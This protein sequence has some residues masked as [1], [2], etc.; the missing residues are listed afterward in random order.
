MSLPY[1]NCLLA[2]VA[3][4]APPA[5]NQLPA[6]EN[7]KP[8]PPIDVAAEFLTRAVAGQDADALKFTVPGT[9]SEAKVGEIRRAGYTST[10]FAIVLVNDTRVEAVTKERRPRKEGEAEGH[11][12][13]MVVK[14]KDGAWRVKDLDVRDEKE[15]RP[16]FVLYL[17]GRYDNKPLKK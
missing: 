5:G 4:L 17:E 3:T 12:V 2:L 16:R 6:A 9:I 7:D 14:G 11:L 15:L 13:I 1:R 8:K 10:A